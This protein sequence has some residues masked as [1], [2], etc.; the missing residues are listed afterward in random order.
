MAS[1]NIKIGPT[2][3]FWTSDR[4]STRLLRKT[5]GSSSYSTL[6]KGGYIITM[7][8]IAMGIEVVPTLNRLRKGTTPGMSHPNNTPTAIAPKIHAVR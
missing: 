2:T 1:T 7:S 8:P 4:P 6:V 3:Q 5:S